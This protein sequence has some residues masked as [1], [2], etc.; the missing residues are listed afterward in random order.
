MSVSGFTVEDFGKLYRSC[1]NCKSQYARH[2]IIVSINPGT[3]LPAFSFF[4]LSHGH[5]GHS[6]KDKQY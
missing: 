3:S 2:V 1:G 4:F 6:P 5:I